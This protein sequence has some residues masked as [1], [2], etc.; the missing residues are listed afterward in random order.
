MSYMYSKKNQKKSNMK[1]NIVDGI[2]VENALNRVEG[3]NP[4]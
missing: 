1:T 4:I 2:L 3:Y